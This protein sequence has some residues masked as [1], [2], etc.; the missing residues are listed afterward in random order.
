[1]KTNINRYIPISKVYRV[2]VEQSLIRGSRSDPMIEI[3]IY[4]PVLNLFR[5]KIKLVIDF[6]DIGYV[7]S[8]DAHAIR[9]K[10]LRVK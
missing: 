8:E 7:D 9:A 5:L 4:K 6:L 10:S 1:M 2:K 3:V